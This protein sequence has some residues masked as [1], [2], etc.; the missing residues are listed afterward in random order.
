MRE[1]T[2]PWRIKWMPLTGKLEH[3]PSQEE[4]AATLRQRTEDSLN[5]HASQTTC[6]GPV[7]PTRETLE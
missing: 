7:S 5:G 3:L 1:S 2:E 6:L 4:M